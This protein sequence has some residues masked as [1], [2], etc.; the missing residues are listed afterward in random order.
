MI[1]A[2]TQEPSSMVCISVVVEHDIEPSLGGSNHTGKY[3]FDGLHNLISSKFLIRAP[4]PYTLTNRYTKSKEDFT[5]FPDIISF[6]FTRL[7]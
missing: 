1:S 2:L 3:S 6:S 7:L 5:S 4:L